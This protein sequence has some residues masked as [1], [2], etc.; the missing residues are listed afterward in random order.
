MNRC[1]YCGNDVPDEFQFCN[2]CG[3]PL[4]PPM[5]VDP[6]PPKKKKTGLVIGLCVGGLVLVAAIV[7]AVLTA[8]GHLTLF[9]PKVEEP[10]IETVRVNLN[11]YLAYSFT[12]FDGYGT[13]EIT[14]DEAAFLEN[15]AGKILFRPTDSQEKNSKS[16]GTEEVMPEDEA[17]RQFIREIAFETTPLEG[18]SNTDTISI[19]WTMNKDALEKYY[20]VHIVSSDTVFTVEGLTP[21]QEI[22]PFEGVAITFEGISPNVTAVFDLSG[23]D[24][25][26]RKTVYHPDKT[27]HL[28]NGDIITVEI[29]DYDPEAMKSTYGKSF[30][31]TTKQYEVQVASSYVT[32]VSEL[33]GLNL[34]EFDTYAIPVYND[35]WDFMS[36]TTSMPLL[37]VSRSSAYLL[38]SPGPFPDS[39]A[40]I[41]YNALV[42]LYE[43]HATCQLTPSVHSDYTGSYSAGPINYEYQFYTALCVPNL[44]MTEGTLQIPY[45]SMGLFLRTAEF[46][47]ND[48]IAVGDAT[49]ASLLQK[50]IAANSRFEVIDLSGD[51]LISEAVSGEDPVLLTMSLEDDPYS[52]VYPMLPEPATIAL[53]PLSSLPSAT[54]FSEGTGD[55]LFKGYTISYPNSIQVFPTDIFVPT[56]DD[57]LFYFDDTSI[58][59]RLSYPIFNLDSITDRHSEIRDWVISTLTA[60]AGTGISFDIYDYQ[61]VVNPNGVRMDVL[62]AH[63]I[64]DPNYP[65]QETIYGLIFDDENKAV[66]VITLYDMTPSDN[67]LDY[68]QDFV[69]ILN[70]VRK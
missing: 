21:I 58:M 12:G 47:N 3:N 32:D 16:D 7:L 63:I 5:I 36:L 62:K 56:E 69:S 8:T 24:E 42:C 18:L 23:V 54:H 20:N 66:I 14:F 39:S 64:G 4:P 35:I 41:D 57:L 50:I 31:V 30:S 37:S 29:R 13:G 38:T 67:T 28:K 52:R 27:T 34:A 51:Q 25:S 49:E 40:E 46:S 19:S 17:A 2:R 53:A 60:G 61:E 43:V 68:T 15:Y 22:D 65:E 33:S 48:F 44:V 6:E 1:P 59:F 70:S 45:D 26:C 55:I 11:N 10:E 9:S